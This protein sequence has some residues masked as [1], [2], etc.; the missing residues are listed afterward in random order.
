LGGQCCTFFSGLA[1]ST[2][3]L[4][5][6]GSILRA[7]RGGGADAK[8]IGLPHADRANISWDRAYLTEVIVM[9]NLDNGA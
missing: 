3:F 1:H 2:L 4:A 5:V 8:Q 9:E 7:W 6:F